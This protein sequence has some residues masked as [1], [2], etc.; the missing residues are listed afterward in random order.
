[1]RT[2]PAENEQQRNGKTQAQL[3]GFARRHPQVAPAIKRPQSQRP[4]DEERGIE[5]VRPI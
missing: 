2:P 5:V 1:M 3:P 4:V